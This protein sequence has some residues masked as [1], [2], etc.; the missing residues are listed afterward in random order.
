M[1]KG[2]NCT[3]KLYFNKKRNQHYFRYQLPS[4]RIGT[5]I[6]N[7]GIEVPTY[8]NVFLRPDEY[9]PL[10]WYNSQRQWFAEPTSQTQ[11]SWNKNT[12]KILD[13]MLMER[14]YE[15]NQ[16]RIPNTDKLTGGD[17]IDFFKYLD[18]WIDK[19]ESYRNSTIKGYFSLKKHLEDYYGKYLPFQLINNDFIRRFEKHLLKAENFQGG[20]ISQ[21]TA[22]KYISNLQFIC[23]QALNERIIDRV[24]FTKIKQTKAK[25]KSKDYLTEEEL[26]LFIDTPTKYINLKKWFLFSCLTGI[27]M[28]ESTEIKWRDIKDYEEY[29]IIEYERVKTKEHYRL[30][31]NKKGRQIIGDRRDDE[32]KVFPY[33][34]KKNPLYNGLQKIV[35]DAGIKKH[36]TPHCGRTT[37]AGLFYSKTK[38]PLALMK[39]MGHKDFK[40]TMAYI[41]KF[42][43]ETENIMPEFE[44]LNIEMVF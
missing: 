13:E 27:P 8:K 5:R 35:D 18:D 30:K 4:E 32:D 12:Q 34:S 31:F 26:Q 25:S 11:K 16:G 21:V 33:L 2:F 40:T 28:R 9:V 7:K 44:D 42:K 10:S 19:N 39:V 15:V 38:D 24:E 22:N 23:Y 14:Q 17:N 6:N 20:K 37:F 1:K 43:D 41:K 36:I 29:S 3:V